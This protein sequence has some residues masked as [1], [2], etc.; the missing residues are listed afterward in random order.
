MKTTMKKILLSAALMTPLFAPF[1]THAS[2]PNTLLNASYD[3]S[4]EFYKD[5]NTLFQQHWKEKTG[6]DVTV[7]QSHGGSSKQAR[8]VADGLEADVVTLNQ[9]TDLDFLAKQKLIAQDWAKQFPN[10]A[11]P[12]TSIS[13][14]LVRKGNPKNIHDWSDLVRPDVR[15]VIPNPKISGN[16]RYAYLAAWGYVLKKG[17]SE[18][19]AIDFE[20]KLF[21]NVPVLDSGGRGATTTFVERGIGDVLV[22]FES[23]ASQISKELSDA[24]FDVVY[25]SIS[26]V[27]ENPVAVV[28]RVVKKHGTREVATEYLN[29]LYSD[30][31]QE[32]AAK[33][34]LRPRSP[35]ALAAYANTFK[36]IPTFTVDEV[37]GGWTNAQKVHFNDGGKFD[38]IITAAGKSN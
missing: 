29:Y 9:A 10:G 38:Q 12:N 5:Y 30:E 4:R 22:T 36:Q 27:A 23:E 16:G 33:N 7:N 18:Q 28:D 35:K 31:A 2:D 11:S 13:V 37:F 34:Y 8:A 14:F 32:L 24:G 1:A 17:G 25:P 20:T 19:D 15:V 3:V 6:K 21:K 26:I